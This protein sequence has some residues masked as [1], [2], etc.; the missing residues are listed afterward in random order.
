MSKYSQFRVPSTTWFGEG[1]VSVIGEE[2]VRLQA[3]KVLLITDK[4][5]AASGLLDQV[6]PYLK[7]EGIEHDIYDEVEPE[8]PVPNFEK[9][10]KIVKENNYDLLIGV[11]GGSSIDIT[12]LLSVMVTNPGS[13]EDYFGVNLIRK[14][15]IPKIA[16]PTTSGTGSEVTAIGILTKVEEQ[17][18]IGVVS[19]H[20]IPDVA[21]VDPALTVGM[22]QKVTATTGMDALAHAIEA[23]TSLKASPLTDKYAIEAIKLIADNLRGAY[24]LGSNIAA[25][26][27][28]CRA[29]YYAGI[30]FA[31]ASVTAV[32]A[33]SFPLGGKYKIPHGMANAIL[34]PYV[35]EF[36]M[37][38]CLHRFAHIA[39]LMGVQVKNISVLDAA[40]KSVD[41][42]IRLAE[43][44]NIPLKLR[45][46]GISEKDIK[47]LSEGAITVTRILQNNPREIGLAEIEKIYKKAL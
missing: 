27:A 45:E 44:I 16:I 22:P 23:Y 14:A 12:K 20:L 40:Q 21:I 28:M 4:S 30:A 25:R 18:K 29:S 17:L 43:D 13:V 5:I 3:S 10:L 11:G 42:V 39:E 32:H 24:A 35:M 46:I 6:L 1:A 36:N 15:G 38:G 26:D 2:C 31:N 41:A 8:P 33:L 47:P 7:S 34:L 19:P 37:I 9:S